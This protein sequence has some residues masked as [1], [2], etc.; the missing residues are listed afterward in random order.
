MTLLYRLARP[1]ARFLFRIFCGV[2]VTGLENVPR[3]GPFILVPNHQS[4]LDPVVVQAFCPRLVHSMTKSTQFAGG[5]SRWLMT[6]LHGFPVRRYRIDP[7]SVRTV[8]RRLEDGE[9]ICIYP[10]GERSW[11]ATLQPF[12]KGTLR[13]LLRA[14]VPVI[15]VGV[16]GAWD[17][18]PRWRKLP[19]FGVPIR[20]RFGKRLELGAFR[21]REARERALPQA[22]RILREALLELSGEAGRRIPGP[23]STT[24]WGTAPAAGSGR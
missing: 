4:I 7:Q 2:P 14:G 13:V 18:W 3:T 20:L 6:H 8:L 15:P 10:E 9:G 5:F 17:V 23:R 21:D 24:P 12:R 19:R 22:E 1:L 11:D 16:D